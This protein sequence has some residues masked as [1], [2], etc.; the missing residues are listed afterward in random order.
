MMHTSRQHN[1]NHKLTKC[2]TYTRFECDM[3]KQHFFL[4]IFFY[5]CKN[6]KHYESVGLRSL[7]YMEF[8]LWMRVL[9]FIYFIFLYGLT[10]VQVGYESLPHEYLT[11]KCFVVNWRKDFVFLFFPFISRPANGSY[12]DAE[13][14]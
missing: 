12:F 5:R 14:K 7:P 10:R 6:R 1:N 4:N 13:K 8:I 2:V 9:L 11:L 3:H